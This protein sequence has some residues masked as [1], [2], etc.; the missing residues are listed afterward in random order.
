MSYLDDATMRLALS[1]ADVVFSRSGSQ[2]YELAAFGK[3]MILVPHPG[4]SSN[5][6][7]RANA[8]AF[9][10]TGAALVIEE[11]NLFPG[12]FLAELKKLLTDN[13]LRAKMGAAARSRFVPNAA[14]VIA[15]EVLKLAA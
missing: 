12:I 8:Y 11:N 10:Q 15:G 2:I 7:Q 5:D 1:A 4:G 6:H 14:D 3:P 13:D 9:A